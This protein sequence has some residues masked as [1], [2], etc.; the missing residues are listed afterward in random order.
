MV[1]PLRVG[2]SKFLD[3]QPEPI[4]RRLQRDFL[5]QL[6][7]FSLHGEPRAEPRADRRL[8]DA[9]RQGILDTRHTPEFADQRRR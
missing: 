1:W 6:R 7:A 3:P 4:S 8:S 9:D 2:K 5:D